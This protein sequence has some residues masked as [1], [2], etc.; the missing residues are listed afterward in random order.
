MSAII[1]AVFVTTLLFL[2]PGSTPKIDSRRYPN[3]LATLEPLSINGTRQWVLMRTQDIRNPVV[4]FVHGGPG[5]SMLGLSRRDTHVLERHFTVVHWD[6]PGAGKSYA[7]G[8]GRARI[9][10]YVADLIAL[11]QLLVDRF[12]QP[13]IVLVGHSWGSAIGMLAAAARPDLFA[14]YVGIGQMSDSAQ[15]ERL[16]YQ[17]TLEQ[18]RARQHRPGL[19]ALI[20]IGPPPYTGADWRAKF[21]RQ[22][23]LLARY[24]GE[25][26]RGPLGALGLVLRNLCC[27]EYTMLDRFN[28]FRGIFRSLAT[29]GPELAHLD[30][31]A[32]VP[33]VKLPVYFCWAAT[34]KRCRRRCLRRTSKRSRRRTNSCCGSLIRRTCRTRSSATSSIASCSRRFFPPFARP[35]REASERFRAHSMQDGLERTVRLEPSPELRARP[36]HRPGACARHGAVMTL[37]EITESHAFATRSEGSHTLG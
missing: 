30:L 26:H 16:S 7:A 23:S 29:L 4:L 2:I 28:Y 25:V 24:G 14:A 5:T 19:A 12:Q 34:T 8:S 17:W 10:E 1:L 18:A 22:R 27:R 33:S 6:Q 9:G 36:R 21:M 15:S 32:R 20:E 11:A 3:S 13:N 31:F 37:P 35:G